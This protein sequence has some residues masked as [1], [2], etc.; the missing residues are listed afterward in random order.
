MEKT[1][2]VAYASKYGATKE[3]AER[4]GSVLDGKGIKADVVSAEKPASI[5]KYD[6]IVAGSA[7]YIGRTRKEMRR[8]LAQNEGKLSRKP[9]WLFTS[10]PTG[11][12]DD[13]GQLDGWHH[14][15][16]MKTLVDRLAPREKVMFAG[17]IFADRLTGIDKWM[18][19]K[20]KAPLS[21]ARDWDQIEK[22]A[23]GIA[24]AVS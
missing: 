23:Q 13:P 20:V 7:V 9:V 15:A 11:E 4:I 24:E 12:N 16:S 18:I 3:I 19:S 1:V 10:G 22:W 6:A 14:P 21:D 5:D 8:F 17:A 2:L